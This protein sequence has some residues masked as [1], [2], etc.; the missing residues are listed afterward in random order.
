[1]SLLGRRKAHVRHQAARVH[2]ALVGSTRW[3]TPADVD[4]MQRF[5]KELVALQPDLILS[6]TTPTTAAL[7]QQTR[8]IPIIFANVGDPVGSGFVVSF[9]QPGGNVTGYN[10]SEPTQAGKWVEL[11]KEIAPRV[12]RIAI[13]FNPASAPYAE[14]WLNPFKAGSKV[15]LHQSRERAKGDMTACVGRCPVSLQQRPT[16]R[17]RMQAGAPQAH[18]SPKV[19]PS[20]A[21]FPE[22][23]R[24]KGEGSNHATVF[25]GSCIVLR[26]AR[27]SQRPRY[28]SSRSCSSREC[29]HR[30]RSSRPR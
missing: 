7:L 12:A 15:R 14:Y 10:V 24:G 8:T 19:E 30:W 29:T 18:L 23:Y 11:L 4:S 13:L 5:A 17:G 27:C 16:A 20:S 21:P 25:D 3:A 22:W 6:H 1:V 26:A 28:C 2:H 9:P